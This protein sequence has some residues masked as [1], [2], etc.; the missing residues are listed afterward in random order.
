MSSVAFR[1]LGKRRA[2]PPVDNVSVVAVGVRVRDEFSTKSRNHTCHLNVFAP[3][4]GALVQGWFIFY[5]HEVSRFVLVT[6]P[7]QG[8]QL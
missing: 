1:P 7:L 2:G 6:P 4:D 3:K 5:L 8:L